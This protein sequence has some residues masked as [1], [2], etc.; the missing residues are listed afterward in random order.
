M[1]GLP[2]IEL[3]VPIETPEEPECRVL[4]FRRRMKG[5]DLVQAGFKLGIGSEEAD[6][7]LTAEQINIIAG[8]C[9][10]MPPVFIGELDGADWFKVFAAVMSMFQ[11]G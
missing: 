3:S 11:P 7:D 10:D 6:L 5:K 9:C 1:S 8:N 2:E 4:K